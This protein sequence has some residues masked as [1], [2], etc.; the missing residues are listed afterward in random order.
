M[1]I[2]Y[3]TDDYAVSPQ[4]A[5]E[6]VAAIR[7]AGFT[8]VI[9]NRPDGEI[10]PQLHTDPMRAAV[11]AA[12]LRFVVNPVI[13]G[14]ISDQNVTAQRAAIDTAEGPVFAYCASG[15]RSSIVWAMSQAGRAP[16]DT[17]IETAARWGYNLEP[18]RPRIDGFA[19][20]T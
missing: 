12:G 11:E 10:P 20:Q 19:A 13:G 5:P 3:L 8:T 16:T 6:D 4:I 14:A 15:N 18:F 17:L 2:R 7:A 9:D 1:E